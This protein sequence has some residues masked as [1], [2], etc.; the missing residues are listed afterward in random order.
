MS[1]A[2]S[3]SECSFTYHLLYASAPENNA[4]GA[5]GISLFTINKMKA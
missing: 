2:D 3:K 5:A 4:I 1:A